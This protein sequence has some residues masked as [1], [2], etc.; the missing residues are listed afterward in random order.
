MAPGIGNANLAPGAQGRLMPLKAAQ[1]ITGAPPRA[2]K[3]QASAMMKRTSGLPPCA[4][5]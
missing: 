5:F 1:G 4:L 3:P 2:K